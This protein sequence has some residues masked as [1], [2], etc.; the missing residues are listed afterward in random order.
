MSSTIWVKIKEKD[1]ACA[2]KLIKKAFPKLKNVK[3]MELSGWKDF[4]FGKWKLFMSFPD[5]EF[6]YYVVEIK[7]YM[8]RW[9]YYVR[10]NE[11]NKEDETKVKETIRYIHPITYAVYKDVEELLID[12]FNT[13]PDLEEKQK[14]HRL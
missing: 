11:I 8:Q 12:D 1:I 5:E 4:Y 14:R 2:R 7:E 13:L 10:R 6:D 3:S 9:F